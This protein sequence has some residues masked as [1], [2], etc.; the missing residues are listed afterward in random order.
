MRALCG[1]LATSMGKVWC[2]HLDLSFHTRHLCVYFG[3]SKGHKGHLKVYEVDANC[4]L[5]LIVLC[6]GRRGVDTVFVAKVF[7]L[8]RGHFERG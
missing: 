8:L 5:L 2:Y 1:Y 3:N 6:V 7:I 4:V